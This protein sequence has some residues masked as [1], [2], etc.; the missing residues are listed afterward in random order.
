M[1]LLPSV[2]EHLGIGHLWIAIPEKQKCFTML[3]LFCGQLC[4]HLVLGSP[5]HVIWYSADAALV[6]HGHVQHIVH[7]VFEKATGDWNKASNLWELLGLSSDHARHYKQMKQFLGKLLIEITCYLITCQRSQ[8]VTDNILQ[9]I[10]HHHQQFG[11]HSFV[12]L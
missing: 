10:L 11:Q 8:W 9:Y 7:L 5:C 12:L 4:G 2:C 6:F 3:L 1:L